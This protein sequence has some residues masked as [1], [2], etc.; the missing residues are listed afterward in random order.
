MNND[1]PKDEPAETPEA[2]TPQPVQPV[3]KPM[4][5]FVVR[6]PAPVKEGD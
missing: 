4:S 3:P 5:V 6:T 2:E 1:P